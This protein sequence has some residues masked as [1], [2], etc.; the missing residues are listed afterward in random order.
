MFELLFVYKMISIP[1][2]SPLHSALGTELFCGGG[3]FSL[4]NMVFVMDDDL[5]QLSVLSFSH[6][7]A[8]ASR[9]T[10]FDSQSL[11]YFGL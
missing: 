5:S 4:Q 6:T 10:P 1:E 2:T 11:F 7:A 9:R 3:G 8:V